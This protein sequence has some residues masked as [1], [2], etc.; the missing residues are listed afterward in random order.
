[1]PGCNSSLTWLVLTLSPSCICSHRYLASGVYWLRLW[2]THPFITG[3]SLLLG[4]GQER[5]KGGRGELLGQPSE[6]YECS[7][8]SQCHGTYRRSFKASGLPDKEDVCSFFFFF[9]CLY[10]CVSVC[11]LCCGA[12]VPRYACGIGAQAQILGFVFPSCE[13]C[14]DYQA[15]WADSIRVLL[16]LCLQSCSKNARI[17]GVCYHVWLLVGSRNPNSQQPCFPLIHPSTL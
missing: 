4:L 5:S 3:H 11:I 10:A 2:M 6:F 8:L 16:C 14:C 12:Y 7:H 1:M 15:G 17:A 9:K 13:C